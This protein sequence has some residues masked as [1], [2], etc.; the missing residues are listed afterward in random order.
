MKHCKWTAELYMKQKVRPSRGIHL[1][2]VYEP[3]SSEEAS[4]RVEIILEHSHFQMKKVDI[5]ANGYYKNNRILMTLIG[6]WPESTMREIICVRI[7][8]AILLVSIMIPQYTYLFR[9]CDNLD[10]MIF[11]IIAQISIIVAFTKYYFVVK[12]M[13]RI[14]MVLRQIREDWSL[15]E[16]SPPIRTLQTYAGRGAF[17]T[18]IYMTVIF[19]SASFF[20]I[21]PLKEGILD[22]L[23]PLNESRPKVFMLD[24]DYSVY[25]IDA[26]KLFLPTLI[27]SYFTSMIVMNMIVSIDTFILII[28]EHCCG[29]FKVVGILLNETELHESWNVQCDIIGNA[30]VI[31]HRALLLAEFIESSFT[32]M[33]AFV[34]LISMLLISIT[35]LESIIKINEL[36]EVTRFSAFLGGQLTHLLF[37][38]LPGQ[39]LLDHSSQVSEDVYG[40]NWSGISPVGKKLISIMLMRSMKP[41]GMTAGGFYALNLENYANVLRTSFS[42]FTV[43]LSNR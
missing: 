32:M 8:V 19:S 34:V 17:G 24:A 42:Y 23:L 2:V 33:Y 14:T 16:D 1:S 15:L 39:E 30:V 36:A 28:V 26:N 4:S 31:H 35:G 11:G 10:D 29:L 5:F 20:S 6:L 13:E 41:S 27:H 25:G 43:M 40:C 18:R 3:P 9:K 38:S 22:R 7:S 12:N 37:M 21:V